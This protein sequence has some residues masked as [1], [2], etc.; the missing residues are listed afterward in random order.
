MDDK[1]LQDEKKPPNSTSFENKKEISE[2]GWSFCPVCA[3]E[4]PKVTNLK[5]CIKCGTDLQYLKEHKRFKPVSRLNP[6]VQHSSYPQY[7]TPMISYGTEKILDENILNTKEKKL[8]GTWDSIWLPLV[9][10]IALNIITAGFFFILVFFTFDVNT[11]TELIS[12]SYFIILISFFELIFIIFPVMYV[13]KHLRNPTLGNRF[14]LLGFTSRG[15]DKSAIF[16]EIL[17]GIL[18]GVIGIFLVFFV[19]V[20]T[21]II[22]ELVFNVDIVYNITSD[23]SD[24]DII[25]SSSDIFSIILFSIVMILIVGPSEEITFRGFMQKGLVRRG[26]NFWG[27]IITALIFSLIH[28]I[29]I[30]LIIPESPREL[31]ISFLLSFFPYFSISM[32]LGLL[33]QWRHENLI[34]VVITHGVYNAL[35]LIFTFIFFGGIS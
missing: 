27:L 5:Y 21:E 13:G 26:G 34:T 7:P 2:L 16:K 25:I 18:F 8:W 11:L 20:I 4:V 10:F 17:L 1:E 33:Y 9:A 29:A 22:L 6:Y 32:M 14:A 30:F 23:T 28:V 19:S 24:I 35:T 15:Y 12:N 3:K 31:I